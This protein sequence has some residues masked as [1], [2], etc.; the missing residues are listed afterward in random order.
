MD[1]ELSRADGSM[2][3]DSET[4]Q[5]SSRRKWSGPS[6]QALQAFDKWLRDHHY[7]DS[8]RYCRDEKQL[9]LDQ[10]GKKID[11][12]HNLR[13]VLLPSIKR[14][15]VALLQSLD[16]SE[17]YPASYPC[18]H[19]ESTAMILSEMH[20]T[21]GDIIS[22]VGILALKSPRPESSHDGRL[23][24]L[25][26][27]RTTRLL[28]RTRYLIDLNLRDLLDTCAA[29]ILTWD[30]QEDANNVEFQAKSASTR[31]EI[32]KLGVVS[33]Y[34]IDG[35]VEWSKLSDFA[36]L[37]EEWQKSTQECNKLLP[38][39][40]RFFD[41]T[42]EF[43]KQVD[44]NEQGE[45]Q[46]KRKAHQAR[47]LRLA[48]LTIPIVKLTRLLYSKLTNRATSHRLPFTLHSEISSK[49]HESLQEK[50]SMLEFRIERL[51]KDLVQIYITGMNVATKIPSF[52]K[53]IL[54]SISSLEEVLVTLAFHIVPLDAT[55]GRSAAQVQRDFKAYFSPL[56][57]QF[58]VASVNLEE[59]A[60]SCIT[61]VD[62]AE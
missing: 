47:A 13:T 29:W 44:E 7:S 60:N 23:K 21:A 48:Q 9:T 50:M 27:L 17:Q 22:A 33:G 14:Q 41:E 12:L 8:N 56:R 49:D 32:S 53:S 31:N 59:A 54:D 51:V 40:S 26:N 25:K 3:V 18:R 46:E 20:A 2:D 55:A 34:L 19:P 45:N 43:R 6:A 52:K 61:Q 58:W 37:Q 16:L 1:A 57:Q 4:E 38:V 15:L 11:V 42:S 30:D 28:P 24:D 36:I 35:I 39:L 10:L 5:A 62:N